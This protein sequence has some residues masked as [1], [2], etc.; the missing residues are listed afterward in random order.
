MPVLGPISRKKLI[1]YL[2]LLGC[3]GPYEGG[4][5]QFMIRQG[6]RFPLPNPHNG[7][8]SVALFNKS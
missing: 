2:L 5:H 6:R 4:K 7:D 1:Q 3:Q 8:I